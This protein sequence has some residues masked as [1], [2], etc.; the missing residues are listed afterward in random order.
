MIK[1]GMMCAGMPES[2]GKDAC[3]GDSGGPAQRGGEL[4][5]IVSWGYGCA[6]ANYPGVYSDVAVFRG[7]LDIHLQPDELS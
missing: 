3:T 5:G 4:V 7:W 6:S 2:G 1:H